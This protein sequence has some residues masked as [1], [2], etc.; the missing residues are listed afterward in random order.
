MHSEAAVYYSTEPIALCFEK[1]CWG[2]LSDPI[3][4]S[5]TATMDIVIKPFCFYGMQIFCSKTIA[6][7]LVN[8]QTIGTI[9]KPNEI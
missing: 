1:N 9:M 7:A 3:A 5:R 4:S 6:L 8:S 2:R